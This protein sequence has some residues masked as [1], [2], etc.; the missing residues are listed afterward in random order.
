MAKH[1]KKYRAAAGKV[2]QRPYQLDEAY[3]LLK[4]VSYAKFNETVELS[5]L[6]GVDP[7]H[8]DQMVR[9]TTLLPHGTGQTKRVLVIA[10]GD[11]Q[12]EA[13]EAG[14]DFV[15]GDELVEKIQG[16]WTDYDAV[17][18]T[19][20][21]MRAVGKLGKVLGP[22]GLMPNP[23]TGTV[24]F[25]VA[26]ALQEIKAGK[27]EF[28]VDKTSI[29]HVPVGKI[30]FSADQLRDNASAIINA[31]RKAKPPAAKGKYVRTI[32]VSS[33]MSPSIQLDPAVAEAKEEK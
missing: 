28:R 4:E 17:I 14:A 23:K 30:Q 25:D 5:M 29:I 20:D 32:Y 21:M 13:T 9:G 12:R 8:A 11:K 19:P 2:E 18:A 24:T 22:R 31:V 6:L 16:G 27:V 15:G 10:N 33:T 7:K 26:K 3:K 1:G